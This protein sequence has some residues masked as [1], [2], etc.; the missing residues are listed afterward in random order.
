MQIVGRFFEDPLVMRAAYA[1]QQSTDW[2]NI[3]GVDFR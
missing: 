3:I 2:D 1:Y